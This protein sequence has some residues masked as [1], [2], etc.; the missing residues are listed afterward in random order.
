MRRPNFIADFVNSLL[1]SCLYTENR[2]NLN[3][4]VKRMPILSMFI[5]TEKLQLEAMKTLKDF[6]ENNDL[7]C[8]HKI[9]IQKLNCITYFKL[10]SKKALSRSCRKF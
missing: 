2:F 3:S 7:L 1:S 6:I 5:I 4:W 8:L 10:S 9:F